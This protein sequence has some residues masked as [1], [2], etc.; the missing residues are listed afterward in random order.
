M[1]TT[2]QVFSELIA[3]DRKFIEAFFV[4]EDKQTHKVPFIYNPIQ[5]DADKTET[6]MDI[7]VKPSQVGFSSGRIAKRLK[8]TLTKPGTN[9]VLI[10]YEDFITERLLAKV[11]YFYNHLS[12]HGIPGF[13]IINNDSKYEKTFDFIVDG[14]VESKSSIYIA[15]ARSYVAGR[16]ETIHHLLADEFAFWAPGAMERILVPAMARIPPGGTCDIFCYDSQTEILSSRGWVKFSELTDNDMVLTKDS[17][18]IAYFTKPISYQSF[19]YNGNMVK[20]SGR[21]MDLLVTPNHQVWSQRVGHPFMFED[22]GVLVSSHNLILDYKMYWS[23][24]EVFTFTVPE[25]R[26]IYHGKRSCVLPKVDIPIDLWVEFLG[27]FLSEGCVTKN[28]VT[29]YQS[30]KSGYWDRISTVVGIVAL[31]FGKESKECISNAGETSFMINDARLSTYLLPYTQPKKIPTEVLNLPIKQ[32]GILL[33]AY[34]DGDGYDKYDKGI[35]CNSFTHDEPLADGLQE[36]GLKVGYY[37]NKMPSKHGNHNPGW[38]LSFTKSNPSCYNYKGHQSITIQTYSGKV[39]DVTIIEPTHLLMVRRNGKPI[40]SGNST[41][42]GLENDFYNMYQMAKEGTSVFKA[43]FYSWWMLPEYKIELGDLRIQRHIPETDQHEFS[44]TSDETRLMVNFHLSYAQI[45]WRRWMIK[46]MES[47]KRQGETRVLFQQEFPEDDVSCFLSTGNMRFDK[48]A[49]DKMAKT[50]YPAPESRDNL[51]IWYKPEQ[52]H[53]YIVSI[54]PG[55]AKIT[56]TSLTVLDFKKD[57]YGN[58]YPVVCARDAGFYLPEI[59]SHKALS[60]SRMYNGALIIWEA[61]AHGLAVTE[62]LK[63]KRPIYFR[64]DIISGQTSME[65][66]WMTTGGAR[67]TKEYMMQLVDRYLPDTVCHDIELVNQLRNHRLVGDKIEI[68]GA[69]DIFMSFAIG[70][71]AYNP[72][73]IKRGYKGSSG[74]RW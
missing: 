15:S 19:D 53:S 20:F 26:H 46:S 73:P 28:R 70:L 37:V 63:H 12:N 48:M 65:P 57:D 52:G 35:K 38:E 64:K 8:Q 2:E 25:Y 30:I 13:P 72:R 24:K 11:N 1:T 29:I 21:H 9:T 62:L 10:A 44:L 34:M 41:P 22:A 69:N 61:N 54:D 36:L 50:C 31:Y 6:G 42:N 23:P 43:H 67:G 55:Q 59:T 47:L 16:A 32:L 56:Q 49:V 14:R 17:D 39:Y 4:I 5:A 71:C 74:W 40:W 66:G 60:I 18:G 58:I 45:R 7:W 33:D 68:V 51:Q 27:Y 3:N